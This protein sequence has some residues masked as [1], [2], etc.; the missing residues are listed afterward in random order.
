MMQQSVIT[1]EPAAAIGSALALLQEHQADLAAFTQ[2]GMPDN[3]RL[4]AHRDDLVKMVDMGLDALPVSSIAIPEISPLVTKE[5]AR[6]NSSVDY[7]RKLSAYFP[8]YFVAA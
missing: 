7:S 4:L 1:V 8:V 6:L 5:R 3:Q 2:P